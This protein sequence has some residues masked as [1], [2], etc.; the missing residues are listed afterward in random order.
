MGGA[1]ASIA[2]ISMYHRYRMY[3]SLMM[4]LTIGEPDD[5]F[6]YNNTFE[7][8][9]TITNNKSMSDH[10]QEDQSE[11]KI[12]TIYLFVYLFCHTRVIDTFQS[13]V[14]TF[15]GLRFQSFILGFFSPK[16]IPQMS[17]L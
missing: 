13:S 15:D 10:L 2:E 5:Y 9:S 16:V 6:Y 7:D 8:Y 1:I 11:C 4:Y 17:H 14:S 12:S 3:Q